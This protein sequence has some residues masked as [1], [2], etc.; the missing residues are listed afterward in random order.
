MPTASAQ[1]DD[2]APQLSGSALEALDRIRTR[3]VRPMPADGAWGWLLPLAITVLG[4][5][6]RFWRIT[7]PGGPRLHDAS[8]IVFDETYYAHDSWSLLHHGVETNGLMKAPAFVVHPPLGKWM[9]AVGEALFDHG[10]TV[11]FHGTVYPA[12]PLAFRFMGAVVGTL[13]ILITARIARRMFRSTALGVVAGALLALDGLEFVQSRTAMLDI[14][15]MFWVIAAFGCLVVDRDWGRRRIAERL[16]RPLDYYE[17]GPR[18]GFRPWRLGAAVCIGAACATKWNG[19]YYV[20]ALI[21]LVIAW[22]L[23]ARRTAGAHGFGVFRARGG[24]F[25][26]DGWMAVNV[27][28]RIVV[29]VVALMVIVPAAVYLASWTGWFLSNAH[30]AYD[31]DKYVH[32]GQSWLSHHWAVLRGWWYYNHTEIW[33]YDKTL[34]ASHPYLSK[35]WGWML[36]E[37]PVAYYY[38]TPGGCGASSCAQ[39]ILG[40][41]NPALWWAAIPAL[42]ATIWI[43]ISRRD[44]RAAGV[45]AAFAFG[46]LPWIYYDLGIVHTNPPC[47][48]AGDC[49]RTMF[50]FYMLPNVPFMVLAVT[51]AV[52]LLLGAR[53]QSE[54]RR[55]LGATAVTGYLAIVVILFYFFYPVL[56]ARNIPQSQW[57]KRIWFTHSC[58]ASAHRN[59][60]HEDAPC[61]I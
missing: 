20:P 28:G 58:D 34:H 8:S 49:H 60:H 42:I 16:R 40:V 13:A 17:W 54:V 10:K 48:P 53:G 61:W 14:Y 26:V 15:L 33:N 43:W 57:H 41:G 32:P 45:I 44:W 18:V 50:L 31:H 30:Y 46:Y 55:A 56:A 29:P 12:S 6:V 36:L 25:G 9:M 1:V 2:A 38:Q 4:G 23:G 21:L 24:G 19:V 51:L 11:T 3:L 47:T 59:E 52:G 39:E 37:R 5:F 35:P 7:R 27:I 22:D